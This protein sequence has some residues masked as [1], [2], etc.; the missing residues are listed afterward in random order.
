MQAHTCLVSTC[1]NYARPL[2]VL[3]LSSQHPEEELL[4]GWK[5]NGVSPEVSTRAQP[6]MKQNLNF[7]AKRK[8][9]SEK[10][11]SS[12]VVNPQIQLFCPHTGKEWLVNFSLIC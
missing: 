7:Y 11:K 5:Q 10:N 9:S 2:P 12:R 4:R 6:G 3:I 1:K 8:Q